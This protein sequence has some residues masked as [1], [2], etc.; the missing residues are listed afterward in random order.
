MLAEYRRVANCGTT[1]NTP[2]ALLHTAT[3]SLSCIMPSIN[4]PFFQGKTLM[5]ISTTAA[6]ILASV[7]SYS[8]IKRTRRVDTKQL[9]KKV[10]S[11]YYNHMVC[12][13]AIRLYRF[14]KA[15]VFGGILNLISNMKKPRRF[16]H[17]SILSYEKMD[18]SNG[19]IAI[20]DF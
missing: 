18:Y 17:Y 4:S 11:N 19:H 8:H 20:L 1:A 14:H 15:S 16:G 6:I 3:I 5:I 13:F 10:R 12:F 7:A 9:R 2:L